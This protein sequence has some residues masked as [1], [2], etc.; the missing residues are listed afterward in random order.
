MPNGTVEPEHDYV[1]AL[2]P[3]S[4]ER[5]PTLT[6]AKTDALAVQKLL[7]KELRDFTSGDVDVV[8]FGSLARQEWTSGSDV[9]WTLLIDGQ[10]NSAHRANA[11]EVERKLAQLQYNGV[12]LNRPGAEGIF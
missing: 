9:D 6:K 4:A 11:R 8:V 3:N 1:A 5:W 12:S 10:A 7:Q 2:V